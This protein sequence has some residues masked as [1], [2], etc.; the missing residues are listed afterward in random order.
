MKITVM[1]TLTKKCLITGDIA[2]TGLG[3]SCYKKASELSVNGELEYRSSTKAS[4]ILFGKVKEVESFISWL[5]KSPGIS[6]L[7]TSDFDQSKNQ[8]TEF[9]IKNTL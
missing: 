9:I 6:L 3:F 2:N 5:K 4:L 8:F 7:D 1:E